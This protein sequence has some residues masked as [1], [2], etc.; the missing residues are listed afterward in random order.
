MQQLLSLF[1]LF[2]PLSILAAQPSAWSLEQCITYA[3]EHN[4]DIK[5][6]EIERKQSETNLNTS[7]MSRLPDLNAG[8]G[9]TWNFG[10][11]QTETGLYETRNQSN[12]GLSIGS[13]VPLFTGL[14]IPSQIA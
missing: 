9:Q 1:I 13:S 8:V 4:L 2:L 5:L 10:R 6:L 11:T 12:T 3:F 14:K 7:Q